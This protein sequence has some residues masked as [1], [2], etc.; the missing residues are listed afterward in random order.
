MF[1]RVAILMFVVLAAGLL[2]IDAAFRNPFEV[3]ENYVEAKRAGNLTEALFLAD[4][5]TQQDV[6]SRS[7]TQSDRLRLKAELADTF[8]TAGDLNKAEKL[9]TEILEASVLAETSRAGFE[10]AAGAEPSVGHAGFDIADRAALRLKLTHLK[11][12]QEH[13]SGAAAMLRELGNE[14]TDAAPTAFNRNIILTQMSPVV[15]DFTELL[16]S[17]DL[18]NADL[19][20]DII[21]VQDFLDR[22]RQVN[23]SIA[24]KAHLLD[25]L[26]S[27]DKRIMD[28][29]GALEDLAIYNLQS[30]NLD[31]AQAYIE[32]AIA[33]LSATFDRQS[34]MLLPALAIEGQINNAR[35]EPKK[36][37]DR[38]E[39]ALELVELYGDPD[40]PGAVEVVQTLKTAY[41]LRGKQ[42]KSERLER[43]YA[44]MID[45]VP[46]NHDDTKQSISND[47]AEHDN[48]E[49]GNWHTAGMSRIYYWSRRAEA[50]TDHTLFVEE[51][52]ASRQSAGAGRVDLFVHEQ[53]TDPADGAHDDGAD[54]AHWLDLTTPFTDPRYRLE[55]RDIV[56]E[57]ENILLQRI[58]AQAGQ[59]P[60]VLLIIHDA[61][62][63]FKDAVRMAA[64]LRH[65]T[66]FDGPVVLL[67]WAAR[68]HR[69]GYRLDRRAAKAA[70]PDFSQLLSTLKK[71]LPGKQVIVMT[72]GT[73][74]KAVLTDAVDG[75][76]LSGNTPSAR[77]AADRFIF[78]GPDISHR[79]LKRALA[80]ISV[81]KDAVTLYQLHQSASLLL[82]RRFNIEFPAG[83]AASGVPK[84]DRLHIVRGYAP[85]LI[86]AA[87]GAAAR[88]D[89]LVYD[90]KR[91]LTETTDIRDRCGLRPVYGESIEYWIVRHKDC[92]RITIEDQ[93]T[94]VEDENADE[95]GK[96]LNMVT[97]EQPV[98]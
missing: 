22:N 92:A 34:I 74:A 19:V 64:Y 65:R 8:S 14:V 6:H 68:N 48:R 50:A 31:R 17:A 93:Q 32:D 1:L 53:K 87:A 58:K 81:S 86:D 10:P 24:L 18:S 4:R 56:I 80:D 25:Y 73:A 63:G 91:L 44:W 11:I 60:G 12:Q 27:D 15:A 7:I 5:L 97:E 37:T 46:I 61:A 66:G 39:E 26:K 67:D 70:A 20:S 57:Q 47:Y 21:A 95:E 3:Y 16:E 40:M 33:Q 43:E 59:T 75:D 29:V 9:Y 90:L 79:D 72:V 62:N 94:A 89:L 2:A 98:L 35:G 71:E 85:G 38:L 45:M 83:D 36:T 42:R 84:S 49:A 28:Y 41:E 78:W 52:G 51:P 13:A 23:A 55:I 69:F 77:T 82:S 54:G 30:D 88:D 96:P 76:T